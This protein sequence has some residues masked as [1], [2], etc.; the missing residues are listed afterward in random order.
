M[1]EDDV[2]HVERREGWAEIALNRPERR[3]AIIPPVSNAIRETLADL[4]TDDAIECVLIRGEGGFFCSGVDLKALQGDPPPDWAGDTQH[5]RNLHLAMYAFGKPIVGAFEK[6]GINAGAALALAC[7]ILIVGETSFLQVGEVQQG[8]MAPMNAAWLAIKSTEQVMARL[9]LY[10][11][12]VPGPELV[13]LGLAAEVASDENVVSRSRQICERLAGFPAGAGANIKR[14]IIE[15]RQIDDPESFFKQPGG[16]RGL[17]A[18][19][20]IK[21]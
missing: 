20:M 17:T 1:S 4:E 21:E 7:D 11:D 6:Y 15:Q 2:I 16:G 3:N 10:G 13:K 8:T 5:W 19:Q 18:A 9:T 12:R 14:I